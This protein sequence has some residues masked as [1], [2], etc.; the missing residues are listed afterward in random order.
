M[1]NLQPPAAIENVLPKDPSDLVFK[2]ASLS[3][4]S[5]LVQYVSLEDLEA[6]EKVITK[7]NVLVAAIVYYKRSKTGPKDRSLYSRVSQEK[8]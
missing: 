7:F 5:N 1:A 2:G 4:P 6:D 3:L 8:K